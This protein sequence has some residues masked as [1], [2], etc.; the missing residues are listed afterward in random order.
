M[1]PANLSKTATYRVL[2][3]K[4][5]W[6]NRHW[7]NRQVRP[8]SPQQDGSFLSWSYL[9]SFLSLPGGV[10]ALAKE[11]SGSREAKKRCAVVPQGIWKGKQWRH[12]DPQAKVWAEGCVVWGLTSEVLLQQEA[13]ARVRK[14]VEW[15]V[16][17]KHG[18]NVGMVTTPTFPIFAILFNVY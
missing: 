1:S 13:R 9:P 11:F 12:G 10:E 6:G 16:G 8:R 5:I 17:S 3:S 2:L 14:K 4:V 7:I 15:A 18:C